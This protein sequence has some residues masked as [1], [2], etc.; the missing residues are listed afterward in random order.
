[1]YAELFL[2]VS[3]VMS[4]A[5]AR[6]GWSLRVACVSIVIGIDLSPDWSQPVITVI[7]CRVITL[8]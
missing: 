8:A 4:D 2:T 5:R 3:H 6:L 1:M 7:S